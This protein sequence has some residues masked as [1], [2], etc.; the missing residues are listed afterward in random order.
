VEVLKD[1]ASWRLNARTVILAE[2]LVMYLLPEA[3][4]SLFCQC[5]E[6]VS[7]GSRF[8]FSY[9]PT[10]VDGRPDAGRWTGLMLWLQKMVGEPWTWSARSEEL[11]SFLK[12]A[13]WE[14]APELEGPSCMYGVEF[15]AVASK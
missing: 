3:V 8:A 14:H 7:E 13:G 12:S 10:G 6:M 2:G 9:I 5:A 11:G 15:Y 1:N 4:L